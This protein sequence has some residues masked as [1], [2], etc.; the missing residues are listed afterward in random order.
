MYLQRIV[1][2][3][4]SF[5]EDDVT[6]FTFGSSLTARVSGL[7][8]LMAERAAYLWNRFSCG[9]SALSMTDGGEGFSLTI[10]STDCALGNGDAYALK[11]D[12][13]GICL[14]AK[15]EKSLMNGFTTLVQLICPE[16]LSEGEEKLYI[17]SAEV[18]DSPAIPFR[19]VHICVFPESTV[20]GI[21]KAIS[22]AGFFGMTH[23]ILEF[24]G[25][26]RY[27]SLSSLAWKDRSFAKDEIKPLI[28][29]IRSYGMEPVPMINHFGHAPQSRSCM[30]R[31]T[32]LNAE[33][34]LS[35]LF[36]PDGW[37]W[38]LSNPDT[39]KLLADMR[40]ELFELFGDGKYFHLG[41]DEAYSFATCPKCRKRVP[42]ELLAEY[43]NRLTED[44][45]KAGRRPIIWHDELI[46]GDEFTERDCPIVA[47]GRSH[48]TA[49]ALDL[50]DKRIIIADWQ[51]DYKGNFNPTT[52]YF[53]KKGFDTLVCP[54]DN[55]ENVR[56]LTHSAKKNGAMGVIFTTWHHLP[57]FLRDAG[58]WGASAWCVD[59]QAPLSD[60]E[61]AALLRRI[62]DA[63]GDFDLSGWNRNEVEQ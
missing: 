31:H 51:Y 61:A 32:I 60:T 30:G 6:R 63:H 8:P 3:T 25:T 11:A 56:S 48:D 41:F 19:A 62:Y 14:R 45:A 40:A 46:R 49:P 7:P 53:T 23:V 12:E 17:L 4:R 39:Y 26:I 20:D 57:A 52:P 37:T 43:L 9:A 47:N 27:D 16:D 35:L 21:A 22:L 2:A 5:R 18:H 1:P 38:C 34:R 54:W 10:G 50:I 55:R 28:N 13:N 15:D 42:S 58:Y 36:E 59:D 44:L 24:W 29:L 33:P